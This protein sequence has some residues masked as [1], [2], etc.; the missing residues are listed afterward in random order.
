[1]IDELRYPQ[2][3]R[4]H[5]VWWKGVAARRD[6]AGNLNVDGR[7]LK[8]AGRNGVAHALP[9]TRDIDAADANFAE[10]AGQPSEVIVLQPRLASVN[11]EY[12]I[13]RIGKE[14]ATI[15]DRDLDIGQ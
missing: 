12:F 6:A 2:N 10:A 5:D 13:Y 8:L 14:E 1:R 7:F 4:R 9:Q 15:E 11:G 3:L